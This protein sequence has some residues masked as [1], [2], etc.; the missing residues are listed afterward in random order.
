MQCRVNISI[1]DDTLER[2]DQLAFEEHK[3][4]SQAITDLVWSAKVK[5][6]QIRG[7]TS[8]DSWLKSNTT[9]DNNKKSRRAKE[10]ADDE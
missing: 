10:N 5:Y 3:S 1:R 7:Q 4:R 6:Q 9:A 2:L 8:M